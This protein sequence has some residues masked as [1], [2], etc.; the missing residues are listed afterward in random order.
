MTSLA[1]FSGTKLSITVGRAAEPGVIA[2]RSRS[3]HDKIS[4]KAE[5]LSQQDVSDLEDLLIDFHFGLGFAREM[6]NEIE[7]YLIG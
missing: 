7:S 6:M 5:T 4:G 3:S 2:S 1:S